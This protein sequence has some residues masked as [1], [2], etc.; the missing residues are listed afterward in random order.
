MKKI[1]NSSLE[2]RLKA[3]LKFFA[4]VYREHII[5]G[6]P[7]ISKQNLI[8]YSATKNNRRFNRL[9]STGNW[10]SVYRN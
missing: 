4:P 5:Q 10:G 7:K 6:K 8:R 3:S 2:K 9:L 1:I